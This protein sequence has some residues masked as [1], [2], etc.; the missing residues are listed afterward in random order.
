MKSVIMMIILL[1]LFGCATMYQTG[2]VTPPPERSEYFTTEMAGFN[3][4]R[5]DILGPEFS[6][7][8]NL[9]LNKEIPEGAFLEVLFE[10]PVSREKPLV[11]TK[12]LK[13]DEESISFNSD[14]VCGLRRQRGYVINVSLYEKVDKKKLLGKHR[15]V[16]LSLMDQQGLCL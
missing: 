13:G 10:N 11:E 2:L 5:D 12:T 9:K 7:F 3:V 16:V 14:P 6:Y 8:I 15:Q 4:H 1:T